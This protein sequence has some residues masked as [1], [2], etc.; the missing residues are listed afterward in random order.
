MGYTED[1]MKY[2]L[3][4]AEQEQELALKIQNGDLDALNKLICANLRLV[5]KIAQEY[6]NH[7]V[8]I[9]DLVSAGNF[10]LIKA[11]EKYKQG[12]GARFQTF[13]HQHIRHSMKDVL[14][15]MSGA[16]SMS[17]GTYG[18][19]KEAFDVAKKIGMDATGEQVA[20]RLGRKK[21]TDMSAVIR[22]GG[23]KVSLNDNVDDKRT[24]LDVIV[25]ENSCNIM[26]GIIHDEQLE[27][28]MQSLSCLDAEER[29]VI[30]HLFGLGVG[31]RKVLREIG[32]ALGKTAERV[33][34]IKENALVKMRSEI[35]R[36]NGEND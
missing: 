8:D 13:A 10:G 34:Q 12:T 20:Q 19:H 25:D 29:F 21:R 30:D 16:I 33:R 9:E 2:D 23:V 18:R 14:S 27:M 3:L 1:I 31:G 7:G 22:G 26:D 35:A 4:E 5:T 17:I 36:M 32:D 28:M 15:K 11:A 24:Y 6:K